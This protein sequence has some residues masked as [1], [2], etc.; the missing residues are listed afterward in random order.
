MTAAEVPTR[1]V[2]CPEQSYMHVCNLSRNDFSGAGGVDTSVFFTPMETHS[3]PL[4]APFPFE[5]SQFAPPVLQPALPP[6]S[7]LDPV[8]TAA[9][10]P[11]AVPQ[12]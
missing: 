2:V 10:A 12:L 6:I 1:G 5:A 3:G 8:R 4:G 11:R 9:L 7:F